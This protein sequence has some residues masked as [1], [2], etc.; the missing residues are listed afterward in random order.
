MEKE[1]KKQK[2][3]VKKGV[4]LKHRQKTLNKCTCLAPLSN[5]STRDSKEV[6]VDNHEFWELCFGFELNHYILTFS[7]YFIFL[8]WKYII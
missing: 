3:V 2:G 7:Y 5:T 8:L 1:N 4:I 6:A